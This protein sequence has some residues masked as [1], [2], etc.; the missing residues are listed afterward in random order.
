MDAQSIQALASRLFIYVIN[1]LPQRGFGI[2]IPVGDSFDFKLEQLTSWSKIERR[3]ELAVVLNAN[4]TLHRNICSAT[5]DGD[6][7]PYLDSTPLAIKAL[8]LLA[9]L[10]GLRQR[11]LQVALWVQIQIIYYAHDFHVTHGV[12]DFTLP[13]RLIWWDQNPPVWSERWRRQS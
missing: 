1:P 11:F 10:I 2:Y 6:I 13:Y 8:F 4:K 12:I 9:R 5:I 3:N 7:F